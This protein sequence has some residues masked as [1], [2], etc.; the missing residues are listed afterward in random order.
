M[1]YDMRLLHTPPEMRAARDE[2]REAFRAAVERRDAMPDNAGTTWYDPE[3][4]RQ[5]PA[6]WV[7]RE[8]YG[9]AG[10]PEWCDIQQVVSDS[11]DLSH[12]VGGEFRLNIWGMGIA[13]Q[14]MGATGIVHRL[15][16]EHAPP[17]RDGPNPCPMC[18]D[19]ETDYPGHDSDDCALAWEPRLSWAPEHPGIC[20]WKFGSNSGWHVTPIECRSAL[21]AWAKVDPV[22]QVEAVT[23]ARAEGVPW[24]SEWLVYLEMAA[25]HDGFLVW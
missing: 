5:L 10:T 20:I 19:W 21:D 7:V 17:W 2:A 1:G 13:R 6:G 22:E 3:R 11:L 9:I 23:A 18:D 24:W 16:E 15:G 12:K 25:S 14:V 8:D 4:H